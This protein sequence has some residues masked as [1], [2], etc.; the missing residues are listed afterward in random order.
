MNEGGRAV[1][2]LLAP[3]VGRE[4][5]LPEETWPSGIRAVGIVQA[6]VLVID[7]IEH[8]RQPVG[9]EPRQRHRTRPLGNTKLACSSLVV[10]R[11]VRPS[12]KMTLNCPAPRGVGGK[13]PLQEIRVIV[14]QEKPAQGNGVGAGL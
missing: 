14:G 2:L 9:G 5:F 8:L 12:A 10:E 4:E 1:A 6:E 13:R 3:G 11:L 7:V